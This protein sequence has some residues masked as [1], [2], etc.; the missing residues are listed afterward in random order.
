MPSLLG[1]IR[2]SIHLM[3]RFKQLPRPGSVLPGHVSI[4][5]MLRFKSE[6]HN[7]QDL[8]RSFNTSNVKVQVLARGY[9]PPPVKFQ[10]I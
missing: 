6:F 9:Y 7:I 5:L 8:S 1:K 2:V 4:H 3:L 10:Y